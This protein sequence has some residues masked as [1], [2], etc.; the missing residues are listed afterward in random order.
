MGGT[1]DHAHGGHAKLFALAALTAARR[2]V[3]G[4]TS[5]VMLEHKKD[6]D[7]IESYEHR[8]ARVRHLLENLAP[9]DLDID[10][11]RI[12]DPFGPSI[13]DPDLDSIFVSSETERG[14][15]AVNVRRVERGLAPLHVISM[16]REPSAPAS[17]SFVRHW[18]RERGML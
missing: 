15:I 7:M 13:T 10:I 5:D 3:V 17:S 9:G 8:A 16:M 1:F 11:V 18:L 12:T 2:I 14:A 6:A 4:V